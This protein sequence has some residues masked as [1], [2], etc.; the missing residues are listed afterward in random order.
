MNTSYEEK[1][2]K[3]ILLQKGWEYLNDN[4]HKFSED[5]KI[6][7]ALELVKKDMPTILEGDI[8]TNITQM[9]RVVIDGQPLEPKI[10]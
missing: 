8:N 1:K 9:G 6:R 2:N 3:R 4:F 5:N 10:D 7:I